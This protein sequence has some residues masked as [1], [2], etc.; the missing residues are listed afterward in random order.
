MPFRIQKKYAVLGTILLFIFLGLAF[1]L[2]TRGGLYNAVT[3]VDYSVDNALTPL[4]VHIGLAQFMLS[5]TYLGNPDVIVAFELCLLAF[6]ILAHRK[7]IAALFLGGMIVGELFSVFFKNLLA[8]SR[9]LESVFHV[10]RVGY[11]FPSGHA[12]LSIIFYGTVGFFCAH[13][14]QQQWQKRIIVILSSIIILLIG[15]SRMFLGVHW[16][17][18][19]LAGWTLGGACLIGVIGVFNYIHHHL[20]S[21]KV[22]NLTKKEL[23]GIIVVSLMLGFFII[24]F[25]VTH[26]AELRS[27]V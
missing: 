5:M 17:S 10:S 16:F 23:V 24:F 4:R 26:V 22:K 25:A 9:P 19:V 11:S 1:A 13:L 2:S 21:E 18:D 8:R 14:V 15:F 6:I 12:L 27:I 3:A 20:R 7:R